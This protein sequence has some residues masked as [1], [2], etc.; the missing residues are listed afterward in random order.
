MNFLK[1]FCPKY[2]L[3]VNSEKLSKK[4]LTRRVFCG[5][6]SLGGA[7]FVSL[8]LFSLAFLCRMSQ[9]V[10]KLKSI[11]KGHAL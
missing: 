10:K 9:F 8:F 2:Y 7:R 4:A 3:L 6:I 1:T 5:I 11:D